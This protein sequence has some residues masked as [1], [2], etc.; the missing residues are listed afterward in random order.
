[1]NSE[2]ASILLRHTILLDLHTLEAASCIVLVPAMYLPIHPSTYLAH[3]ACPHLIT[4]YHLLVDGTP[5]LK[6]VPS[7]L[8]FWL[9]APPSPPQTMDT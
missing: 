2:S 1:M 4:T 9:L 5:H 3:L 8:P 6:P 7:K